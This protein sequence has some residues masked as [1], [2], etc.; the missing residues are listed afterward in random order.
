MEIVKVKN[1]YQIVI[2]EEVRKEANINIGDF[3]E[4][5]ATKN[6][7]TFEPK[8][9]VDRGLAEALKEFKSSKTVGPFKNSTEMFRFIDSPKKHR[10]FRK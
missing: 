5:K 3:L 6:G 1:K 4:V 8:T 7:I 9:L 2:H 10:K